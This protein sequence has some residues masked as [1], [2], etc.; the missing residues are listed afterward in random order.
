MAR[1]N[2]ENF[3]PKPSTRVIHSPKATCPTIERSFF[4]VDESLVDYEI[5]CFANINRKLP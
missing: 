3:N 2:P 1:M 4:L 5:L